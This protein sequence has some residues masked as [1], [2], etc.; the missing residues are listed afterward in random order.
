MTEPSGRIACLECDLL[1]AAP[2]VAEGQRAHC[3]RCGHHLM[4]HPKDGLTRS[5]AFA[6][7]ALMLMAV[8]LFFPFLS[9]KAS[10]LENMITLPQA[11]GEL[12][13][14]DM[15]ILA[16]L[17][18]GFIL[19]IPGVLLSAVLL[20][21]APLLR[22]RSAPWLVPVGRFIFSASSWSMVEVFVI[23]VIVSLVKLAALATINL[24]ISFWAY[25]AFGICLTATLSSL[26]KAYVWDE[27]EKAS[28]A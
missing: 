4:A 13:E 1:L 19:I 15:R 23:G 9:M 26:D 18:M 5:F 21:L 17:V 12:W 2:E 3:P 10:G 22:G 11:A 8:S 28:R 27:I 6:A 25:A 16:I 7:A 20:L 14:N 24:G